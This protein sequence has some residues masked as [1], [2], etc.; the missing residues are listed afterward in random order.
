MLPIHNL[1]FSSLSNNRLQETIQTSLSL[2]IYYEMY[3]M[4]LS[5]GHETLRFALYTPDDLVIYLAVPT[6]ATQLVFVL[7][8]SV[9][10]RRR[11]S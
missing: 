4:T 10:M 1:T 5:I 3:D 11:S 2:S 6:T 7:P 8:I 9:C